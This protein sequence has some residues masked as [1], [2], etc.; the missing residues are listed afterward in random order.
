MDIDTV[1]R[2]AKL[3]RG[4]LRS[5][6]R[7][8]KKTGKVHTVDG[9]PSEEDYK[10]HL[11][12]EVG[13]GLV[14]VT[15]EGTCWFGA[16]D[17]DSHGDDE[18]DIDLFEVEQSVREAD[19]PLMVCRS[20]SGGAHLYLFG[21][22]PLPAKL[23]RESLAKWAARI[24]FRGVEVFP[25]QDK[26]VTDSDGDRQKGNWINLAWFDAESDECLRYA[27]EGGRRVDLGYFLDLAES[28]RVSSSMLVELG[29]DEH[30]EAPPCI[31]KMI[32]NGVN[33]GQRNEALYNITVYLK[34]AYPET[35]SDKAFDLNARV[36]DQP[37]AFAEAKKTIKSAG[38]RDY[39]YRCGEEP[40]RS[41]CQ[42][43]ICVQ[44]KFGITQDDKNQMELGEPPPFGPLEKVLTDPPRWILMVDNTPVGLTTAEL[45]DFRAVRLAV[46][47]SMTRLIPPMKNERW[48]A[49][50]YQ[51][52][53]EATETEAPEEASA[54]GYIK[55]RLYEFFGRAD[56]TSDGKNLDDR[57]S[58]MLGSPVVQE[59]TQFGGRFIYFRGSDFID[60][61]KKSRSEELKGSNLWMALRKIG[62]Q[63]G[64]IRVQKK[65]LPVWYI[66]LSDGDA[67]EF[68]DVDVE[69]EI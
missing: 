1:S 36:F 20:K 27:V 67:I 62:V 31:Q 35:W 54:T 44:R 19:L 47:D 34:K 41:L 45:M 66:A 42:S 61:L 39:R 26:L 32:A 65:V 14:P 46:A 63:H 15:D 17:I 33:S 43:Y 12:G 21:L 50:L 25:K 28:R 24:G 68:T 55:S 8:S 11:G 58:L 7:W 59:D 5:F 10:K 29:A 51:L 69:P 56:L 9:E 64:R 37:L 13:L 60:F 38:R 6:G 30:S 40:C 3:F 4:N 48:Q 23:V 18:P 49:Q 2:Y 22:E 16:I 52:M 53:N 57:E